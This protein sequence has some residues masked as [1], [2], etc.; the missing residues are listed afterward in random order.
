MKMKKILKDGSTVMFDL[1]LY[2]K[3]CDIRKTSMVTRWRLNQISKHKMYDFLRK[4][5]EFSPIKI[6][7]KFVT[8][9]GYETE[10]EEVWFEYAPGGWIMTGYFSD[11]TT[12]PYSYEAVINNVNSWTFEGNGILTKI[13]R[14]LEV[15]KN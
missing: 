11:K 8:L 2:K 5:Y 1:E 15:T 4:A 10:C 3:I 6:G 12:Y 14:F 13:E 9:D 7:T